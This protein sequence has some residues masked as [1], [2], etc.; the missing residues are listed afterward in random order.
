MN[1]DDVI[2]IESGSTP[3]EYLASIPSGWGQGRA[4]YGG[5]AGAIIVRAAQAAVS[6]DRPVRSLALAFAGPLLLGPVRVQVVTLRS[7]S[8]TTH[9][10]V[11]LIQADQV[12]TEATVVCAADRPSTLPH[13]TLPPPTVAEPA[14]LYAF[15][16]MEGLTPEFTQHFDFRWTVDTLPFSG[17]A[18]GHVQGW[19]RC[20]DAIAGGL[21]LLTGLLDAW[22][23]PIWAL[24]DEPA[25][26]SSV[27]WHISFTAAAALVRADEYCLF[28]SVLT[29]AADGY[30][31]CQSA[32]WNRAGELVALSRQFFAD[33]PLVRV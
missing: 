21:P 12:V 20:P 32:M 6:A 18:R 19:I 4:A 1:L 16:Y 27:N 28:D 17:S 8:Q 23:P 5:V 24:Y 29:F 3:G 2:A 31:D 25:R 7:G 26:G 33:Y 14:A 9:M 22:P 11:S 10:R 13:A 30:S 15:P